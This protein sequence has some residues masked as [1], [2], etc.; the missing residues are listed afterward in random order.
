MDDLTFGNWD[1]NVEEG[2]VNHDLGGGKPVTLSSE[3]IEQK[4]RSDVFS[5]FRI[6]PMKNLADQGR[7]RCRH[8]GKRRKLYC[9][10]CQVQMD[11]CDA[12]N[13]QLPLH[14]DI[15][16]HPY[17][18]DSKSTAI[19]AKLLA[20]SDVSIHN[21]PDIP[22]FDPETTLVLYPCAEASSIEDVDLTHYKHVVF[23]DSTWNKTYN[24]LHS[25]QIERLKRV[26]IHS[27]E[28]LF[29]RYQSYG[30]EYLATI[31]AI[32]YFVREW[33]TRLTD[34]YNGEYD[35]LLFFFCYLYRLIQHRYS[36]QDFPRI[37]GWKE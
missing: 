3:V 15:V 33:Q 9:Y 35:D 32:Y 5:K 13:L 21:F 2:E 36:K 23:V 37:E 34:E 28:T 24:I 16:K 14:V 22:Y 12:P 6:S 4:E 1:F 10:S 8:C 11:G 29:W 19:H 30:R 7:Q 25:P 27:Y 26:K 17:E 18:N 20:P 31:E